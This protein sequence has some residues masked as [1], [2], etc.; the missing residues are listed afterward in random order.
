MLFGLFFDPADGRTKS[1]QQLKTTLLLSLS[2]YFSFNSRP[3]NPTMVGL[4][5]QIFGYNHMMIIFGTA[6]SRKTRHHEMESQHLHY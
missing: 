3:I 2:Q 1:A 5:N 6:S 4:R